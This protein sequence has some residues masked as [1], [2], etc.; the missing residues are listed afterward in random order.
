M[1]TIAIVK[2]FLTQTPEEIL[3]NYR[4]YFAII[5]HGKRVSDIDSKINAIRAIYDSKTGKLNKGFVDEFNR[6]ILGL[7]EE[8]YKTA[9]QSYNA[10]S[11]FKLCLSDSTDAY[12]TCSTVNQAVM[13]QV[14][15]YTNSNS[16]YAEKVVDVAKRFMQ[17]Y[18]STGIGALIAYNSQLSQIDKLDDD[19]M[20]KDA[21]KEYNMQRYVQEIDKI[22]INNCFNNTNIYKSRRYEYIM[23]ITINEIADLCKSWAKRFKIEMTCP[24]QEIIRTI[25]SLAH[26]SAYNSDNK[27]F[28]YWF[29]QYFTLDG[30]RTSSPVNSSQVTF[31]GT[32]TDGYTGYNNTLYLTGYNVSGSG[33]GMCCH[34]L[35]IAYDQK[36]GKFVFKYVN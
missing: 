23:M 4:S 30:A 27:K 21:F 10:Q 11:A 26:S 13:N 9:G 14:S 29:T 12:S 32:Y 25:Y 8:F 1:T 2:R 20:Y 33:Q 34:I 22:D 3:C 18:N 36:E 35:I 15:Y 6:T 31:N 17:Y 24:N 16:N 19:F 28:G 5:D 7:W